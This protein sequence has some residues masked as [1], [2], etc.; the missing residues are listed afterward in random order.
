MVAPGS[1]PGKI[2]QAQVRNTRVEFRRPASELRVLVNH[3]AGAAKDANRRNGVVTSLQRGD[4]VA[5]VVTLFPAL[6]VNVL[7][8]TNT[9][10]A[11]CTVANGAELWRADHVRR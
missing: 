5:G 9:V 7:I 3:H 4:L 10:A 11:L 6:I 2:A 1:R 8:H